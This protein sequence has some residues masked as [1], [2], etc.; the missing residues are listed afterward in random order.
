MSIFS[1]GPKIALGFMPNR[2]RAAGEAAL[3]VES[4]QE[5]GGRYK[6]TH[7]LGMVPAG[8]DYLSAETQAGLED[9][10]VR[11]IPFEVDEQAL[12]FPLG[13]K[14]FAAAAAE[15]EVVGKA[16]V[17]VWMDPDTLILQEPAALALENDKRL[18]YRPVHHRLIGSRWEAP[19]DDFWALVYKHCG[20]P[21][22]RP[23]PMTTHLGDDEIRPYFNAG[24]LVVRP[25][26]GLLTGW[27]EDFSRLFQQEA[28]AAFYEQD[29]LYAVF[30]HQAVLGGVLLNRL[31]PDAM[32]LLPETFNYP[33]H[34]HHEVPAERRPE[35]LNDLVT[36]RYDALPEDPDWWGRIRIDDPLKSWLAERVVPKT[37]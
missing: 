20:V 4:L 8:E 7:V 23:F 13:A 27:R 34:L 9:R 24:I 17:L 29:P 22:A 5:F 3:L 19:L 21:E 12:K 15:G 11:L 31:D 2:G 26:D 14:V 33:L 28:F 1:K 35:R 32:N 10:G 36:C 37:G 30:M 25:E 18:G 6:R 16:D